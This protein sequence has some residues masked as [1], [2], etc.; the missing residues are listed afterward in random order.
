METQEFTKE[1]ERC[2][3]D[4][5]MAKENSKIHLVLVLNQDILSHLDTYI[6]MWVSDKMA[7]L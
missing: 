3:Q 2:T 5:G 4:V 6:T 1:L 7:H